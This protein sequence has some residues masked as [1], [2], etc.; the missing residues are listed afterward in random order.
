MNTQTA[1]QKLHYYYYNSFYYLEGRVMIFINDSKSFIN[2]R[3]NGIKPTKMSS[4]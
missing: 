2:T 4:K 3:K 1:Q